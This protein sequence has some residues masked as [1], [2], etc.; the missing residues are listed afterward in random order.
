LNAAGNNPA[1]STTSLY[2]APIV[3]S[4]IAPLERISSLSLT[5]NGLTH[6]D[7][8]ALMAV[9]RK[10]G[11]TLNTLL[12]DGP[13]SVGNAASNLNLTFQDSATNTLPTSGGF[14]SGSY[15]PG[16]FNTGY[17]DALPAGN[18][19]APTNPAPTQT[20]PN[21]PTTFNAF[22]NTVPNG[23]YDLFVNGFYPDSSGLI[24]GWQLNIA[25]AVIPESGTSLLMVSGALMAIGAGILR[26][27]RA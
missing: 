10:S 24:T 26:R 14:T 19:A 1:I 7:T 9:F 21:L 16:F 18:V 12:F 13:G 20:A 5:I 3:V 11:T 4:G 27:R 25:T 8:N 22:N 2:P 23:T 15:K 6:T 17:N